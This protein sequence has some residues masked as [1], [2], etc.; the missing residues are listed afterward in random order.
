[1]AILA[2]PR[3]FLDPACALLAD[4]VQVSSQK[5]GLKDGNQ[6]TKFTE[7]NQPN[8]VESLVAILE[9]PGRFWD[10]ACALLADVFQVSSQKSAFKARTK[11][12]LNLVD[13]P[14]SVWAGPEHFLNPVC[15]LVAGVG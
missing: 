4:V 12:Q 3:S 15:A 14:A 8:L 1:M 2:R 10:L 9:G 6:A 11:I 7:K 13:F 5:S